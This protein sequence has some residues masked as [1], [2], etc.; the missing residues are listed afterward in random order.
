MRSKATLCALWASLIP[1]CLAASC[2]QLSNPYQ[3]PD[4]TQFEITCN[5]YSLGGNQIGPT[6]EV[7]DLS[8]CIELCATT[9]GCKA[10]LFDRSQYL[11]YTLDE[12]DGP[13]SNSL[14]DMAV[15]LSSAA[16]TTAITSTALPTTT[17]A[18]IP[19][20]TPCNQLDNPSYI[21]DVKFTIFCGLQATGGNQ[22]DYSNQL[23][24]LT[25]CM[26]F[27]ADTL[28]CR[29]V[30]FDNWFKDCYLYDGFN[31]FMSDS[32]K[33]MAIASRPVASSTT[34]APTDVSTTTS[35]A[36]ASTT[37]PSGPLSC[38]Q[39]AG[40][41]YTGP[42]ENKFTISCD[43]SST[44][45]SIYRR[46]E[47]DSMQGC[48]DRCD[49]E[50]RCI[51]VNFLPS[52][53]YECDLI[54][55]FTGTQSSPSTDFA[56]K[57]L[58]SASTSTG[59]ETSASTGSSAE[60][61]ASTLY[62]SSSA[63]TSSGSSETTSSSLPSA[64]T[65]ETTSAGTLE[66]LSSTTASAVTSEA[67]ASLSTTLS[68]S[69]SIS[70]SSG[71]PSGTTSE[72][73]LQS[74][75]T[76]TSAPTSL[77]VISSST[78]LSAPTLPHPSS[79]L[80]SESVSESTSDAKL[81]S[82][83]AS[84]E[85]TTVVTSTDSL[86]TDSTSIDMS[87]AETLTTKTSSAGTSTLETSDTTAPATTIQSAVTESSLSD[88]SRVS[89]E[90]QSTSDA[91]ASPSTSS[92][93]PARNIPTLGEYAFTGCLK[94]LEGYPSFK[95]VASDPKMTTGKCIDLASGSKYI[96]VYQET[97]YKADLFD[98]TELIMDASCDLPCP[99]DRTLF[100]GGI[101]RS[102]QR[103][104][105]RAIAP[106][107]LLTLYSKAASSSD[108]TSSASATASASSLQTTGAQTDKTTSGSTS[109]SRY[110]QTDLSYSLSSVATRSASSKTLS[111]SHSIIQETTSENRL[112][113]SVPTP[114]A[115]HTAYSTLTIG[116]AYIKTR[117]AE[118]VTTVTYT[119]INPSNPASL[120]TT[121][122]PITLLYSP[123]G[124]KH[125]VYPTV[126]MTTVA[127]THGGA[128]ATLTVP[129]AAYETG[130]AI[131]T[132][133]IVQYPSGWTG[134]HQTDAG[135]NSYPAVQSTR[136][137]QPSSKK[138]QPESH[139]V[140]AGPKDSH[141]SYN[142]HRPATPA[143]AIGSNGDDQPEQGYPQ[144]SVA[145]QGSSES[146][147]NTPMSPSQPSSPKSLITETSIIPTPQLDT[148][149]LPSQS[150]PPR[151]S[152]VP[153]NKT[154]I[155]LDY[156]YQRCIADEELCVFW[157]HAENEASFTL[158]YETIG[159]EL[160]VD[161]GLHGSGLLEA[162]RRKIESRSRWLLVIDNADDLGLFGVGQSATENNLYKYIPC[163]LQGTVLWTSRDEHIVG[164]LVGALRG[165]PV[166]PM[167]MEEATA[168]L[169][170]ARG[171]ESTLTE[172]KVDD[173]VT[174]LEC[175]PLA[176]SQAGR[177]M[178]RLSMSA[179]TY[180]DQL[181]Q[182]TTRLE[183]LNIS[184]TDR[185]RR[186]EASN[187][188]LETWRISTDRI[189]AESKM[190]YY[191]LHVVAYL[192]Y[193]NIPEELMAA[194]AKLVSAA[195]NWRSAQPTE[196]E[197]LS[198]IARLRELSFIS[199]RN[200]GDTKPSYEMHKLVQEALRY[201]MSLEE[202]TE[203]ALIDLPRAENKLK[204]L[205]R[206][207]VYYSR[208]AL[209]LICNL[210]PAP[211]A[212]SW[213][214]CEQFVTHAIRVSEWAEISKTETKTA[215]LLYYVAVFLDQ[216]GRWGELEPVVTHSIRLRQNSLGLEH[217]DTIWMK[218]FLVEVIKR[219]DLDKAEFV[220]QEVLELRQRVL[221]ASHPDVLHSKSSLAGIYCRQ[222]RNTEAQ[223]ILQDV[224]KVQQDTLGPKDERTIKSMSRLAHAYFN[225][226][227]YKEAE[228]TDQEVLELRREILGERHV[229][230]ITTLSSLALTYRC[231][232]QLGPCERLMKECLDLRREVLGN[233]HPHTIGSSYSFAEFHYSLG[234]YREAER[235]ARIALELHIQGYG[236]TNQYTRQSKKLLIRAQE[237]LQTQNIQNG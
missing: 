122:V 17:T 161:K 189:W 217:P 163:T 112:P 83:S 188:I 8:S 197:I 30:T 73:A 76:H 123:C 63:S 223:H 155:A 144:P 2:D 177:F 175:L 133:P 222:G 187:S 4:D 218:Q 27:C 194:A 25:E 221:V 21:D 12:S 110:S 28:A 87:A 117:F 40:S 149:A 203:V 176:V 205:R 116:H 94:S 127:C 212:D 103:L 92:T 80:S 115:I 68:P 121:C 216:R 153:S 90:I 129:K 229:D 33:D 24:S 88:T 104:L 178:R 67:A 125:Q 106:N 109:T 48:V 3:G 182:R 172:P 59:S 34:E 159:K 100:C 62:A 140:A 184:D 191:I 37:A 147:G 44:G 52:P 98:D 236:E 150:S 56:S 97:C 75:L 192:D 215:D 208:L 50:S 61:T 126:D 20:Q 42:S 57:I 77:A 111:A 224:L 46:D 23:R 18:A 130:S 39:M 134:G 45:E 235:L 173:L 29:A 165:L 145:A 64:L 55:S 226:G 233:H 204:R 210:F 72:F 234:R 156:A 138:G 118:T 60:S 183:L 38:E 84:L 102:D 53:Y 132:Y 171:R 219:Q 135:G 22:V 131:Y 225:Q 154:Q 119:T 214:Q 36:T 51:A 170:V 10:A 32:N 152:Q 206:G 54:E 230:T 91:S 120:I 14:Y 15:L 16:S 58:S 5:A 213:A 7:T 139:T 78:E 142:T 101:L 220:Q 124:C 99:G 185:Y 93:P 157:V 136:G 174:E 167:D 193:Q 43:T 141:P 196:L 71:T 231:Q 207:E 89:T 105:H 180:L 79:S 186:P 85:P 151:Q 209:Q 166:Q 181:K 201:R 228:K 227:L 237:A 146:N 169:T 96:G 158:D 35:M 232:G 81:E 202:A 11:C 41:V 107:R 49:R 190:S 26:T 199:L 6:I 66:S 164:T 160:G 114:T 82:T 143:S 95:E 70:L 19:V 47:E 200:S 113:T 74:T 31:G 168:L 162:V 86:H 9:S 69:T 198:S 137:S 148:S 128:V 195:D 108:T 211:G 65:S 1:F 179:E 13:A